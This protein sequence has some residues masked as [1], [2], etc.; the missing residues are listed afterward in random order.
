MG[1]MIYHR[2]HL[3]RDCTAM[4]ATKGGAGMVPGI[5]LLNQISVTR[6]Q[7]GRVQLY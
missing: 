3:S 2:L 4:I 5:Y 7:G 1:S 6:S